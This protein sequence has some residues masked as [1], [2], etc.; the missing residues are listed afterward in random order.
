MHGYFCSIYLVETIVIV[1]GNP[2]FTVDELEPLL[3]SRPEETL[4][5]WNRLRFIALALR[6]AFRLYGVRASVVDART[7][8][9]SPPLTSI[10]LC[11]QMS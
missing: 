6:R 2:P 3:P 11:V 4:T 8:A 10:C 5:F 9:V 7:T 1:A